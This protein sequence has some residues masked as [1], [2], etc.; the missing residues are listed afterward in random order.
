MPAAKLAALARGTLRY[1]SPLRVGPSTM[2][3]TPGE[4]APNFTAMQVTADELDEFELADEIGDGPLVLGFFPF[5]FTGGCQQQ[6]CDLRDN[7]AELE[8]AGAKAFGISGDTPFSLQ[9]WHEENGFGFPLVSDLDREGIEAFGVADDTILGLPHAQR[10]CFILDND[11][12]VAWSWTT[13]DPSVTPDIE[14]IQQVLQK[15]N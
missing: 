12:N 6:M 2:T 15:L 10:A 4:P 1:L 7:L 11:G 3:V 14:E 5:A 9:V 8:A 13:E